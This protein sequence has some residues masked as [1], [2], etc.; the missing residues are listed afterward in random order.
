MGRQPQRD[1]PTPEEDDQEWEN[2]FDTS[3]E[4]EDDTD[5]PIAT[6]QTRKRSRT[7]RTEQHGI[8][9]APIRKHS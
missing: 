9:Y 7:E 8:K 4:K 1:P 5:T 3:P 2:E 6:P